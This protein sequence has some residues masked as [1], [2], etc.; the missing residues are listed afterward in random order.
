M[1]KENLET[2]HEAP[3]MDEASARIEEALRGQFEGEGTDKLRALLDST[4]A[5]N[6]ERTQM[7]RDRE[8]GKPEAESVAPVAESIDLNVKA[9]NREVILEAEAELS[10]MRE[11][12]ADLLK[13][14]EETR[15]KA[16]ELMNSAR[17]MTGTI[18]DIAKNMPGELW[19]KMNAK[20]G[21]GEKLEALKKRIG[22]GKTEQDTLEDQHRKAEERMNKKSFAVRL[23]EAG[24]V[25]DSENLEYTNTSLND[26]KAEREELA[27][28]ISFVEQD[29]WWEA[30][31]DEQAEYIAKMQ[32]T[33][34]TLDQQI[35][36]LEKFKEQYDAKLEQSDPAELLEKKTEQ[37]DAKISEIED[38][39]WQMKDVRNNPLMHENEK[40]LKKMKRQLD[41]LRDERDSIEAEVRAYEDMVVSPAETEQEVEPVA[42]ETTEEVAETPKASSE[43]EKVTFEEL[44]KDTDRLMTSIDNTL[45]DVLQY[46]KALHNNESTEF[47]PSAVLKLGREFSQ[48]FN[49]QIERSIGM[50]EAATDLTAEERTQM[51]ARIQS[52]QE[53]H[54][55]LG[56]ALHELQSAMSMSESKTEDNKEKLSVE[57]LEAM[58]GKKQEVMEETETKEPEAEL[59]PEVEAKNEEA[60]MSLSAH[61][62]QIADID[63]EI[64]QVKD[65]LAT[66][67]FKNPATPDMESFNANLDADA[68]DKIKNLEAKKAELSNEMQKEREEFLAGLD[69]DLNWK[70]QYLSDLNTDLER[71]SATHYSHMNENELRGVIDKGVESEDHIAVFETSIARAEAYAEPERIET[72]NRTLHNLREEHALLM[73]HV[74]KIKENLELMEGTEDSADM[75]E[76]FD[77]VLEAGESPENKVE[78]SANEEESKPK[79]VMSD[80]M[81]ELN[82]MAQSSEINE[83]TPEASAQKE[84]TATLRKNLSS[85][86]LTGNMSGERVLTKLLMGHD[87]DPGLTASLSTE[88]L[89]AHEVHVKTTLDQLRGLENST[90]ATLVLEHAV[91]NPTF[92]KELQSIYNKAQESASA[93]QLADAA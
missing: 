33:L 7:Q 34:A 85:L 40:T 82:R 86:N 89:T 11:R 26:A 43:Q 44:E 75:G 25:V 46:A 58:A 37:R 77:R 29:S 59:E 62:Q 36:N 55:N 91:N 42:E 13:Q 88:L 52:M 47:N 92:V 54:I 63:A 17:E 66:L 14:I 10:A 28:T 78:E 50:L 67:Q 60:K 74:A 79:E 56:L 71:L 49:G 38:L 90:L 15:E 19:A 53:A 76:D 1:S 39:M 41:N 68:Q 84:F 21:L 32:S 22:I 35:A 27:S 16:T 81:E 69:N 64:Q 24:R 23:V 48:R 87:N 72:L 83:K 80:P 51:E 2:T 8:S 6:M 9:D 61:D 65:E 4:H 18:Q 70:E 12:M 93:D 45:G 31:P 73:T 57:D 5:K 30:K 20:F 3:Q